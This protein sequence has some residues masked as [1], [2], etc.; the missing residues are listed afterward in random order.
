M[1]PD[2]VPTT[3]HLLINNFRFNHYHGEKIPS[4][5]ERYEGQV[6]RVIE[7]LDGVLE[8]RDWLVGD[9]CTFADLAFLPWND[10][11]DMLVMS[12]LIDE[13]R[14]QYPHFAAWQAR[15]VGRDSWK[16]A[17]ETRDQIMDEQGLMPN[18]MPKGITNMAQYE[19]HM[20]KVAEE[21]K[22]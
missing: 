22:D 1:N 9:K 15:M 8:D 14:G 6:L 3:R 12:K 19:E 13:I 21:K 20:A 10:R 2:T 4:A 7:V 16:R 17:M 11:I 18:G 5:I